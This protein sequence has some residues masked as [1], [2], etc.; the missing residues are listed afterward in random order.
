M[1]FLACVAGTLALSSLDHT[2]DAT[3]RVIEKKTCMA[4]AIQSSRDSHVPVIT[5]TCRGRSNADLQTCSQMGTVP[6]I[7]AI[8][9]DRSDGQLR[10][11][12]QKKKCANGGPGPSEVPIDWLFFSRTEA[13]ARPWCC[14]FVRRRQK[15][16]EKPGARHLYSQLEPSQL[17][18]SQDRTEAY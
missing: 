11:A 7:A 17:N 18:D 14:I 13:C 2:V 12:S 9:H 6:F 15:V 5:R 16:G 3:T 1:I 8:T 10:S 4:P